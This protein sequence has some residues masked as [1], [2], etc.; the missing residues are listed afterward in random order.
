MMTSCRIGLGYDIHKT[1]PGDHVWLGGVRIEAPFSL[2]GHSDADVL[3]HVVDASN[4]HHPEQMKEVARVLAEIGAEQVPQVLVFNKMDALENAQQPLQL[5]DMY[6]LDG[7]A[8]PRLFVSARSGA[9]LAA[10]REQLVRELAG[11][12]S[13]HAIPPQD[14]APLH[15]TAA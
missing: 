5:T 8:V 4:P 15:E 7:V 13:P 9:G 6:E 12:T 10:L 14:A 1:G 2:V 11:R 3:L